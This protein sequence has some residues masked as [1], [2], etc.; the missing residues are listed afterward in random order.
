[1]NAH[2]IWNKKGNNWMNQVR[3]SYEY[4]DFSIL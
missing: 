3:E 1:M 2:A 4:P